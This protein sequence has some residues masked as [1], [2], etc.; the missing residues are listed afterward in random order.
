M[1]CFVNDGESFPTIADASVDFVFSFDSLVHAEGDVMQR[2]ICELGRILTRDGV[3]FLH[4]SNLAAIGRAPFAAGK[5]PVIGRI[6]GETS[7]HW[8]ARSVDAARV[9][10]WID[11]ARLHCASQELVNW[12]TRRLIDCITVIARPGSHHAR[13]TQIAPNAGFMAEARSAR[14]VSELYPSGGK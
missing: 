13:A 1:Q 11:D 2:Y 9:R 3:A 8:R 14:I 7:N 6:V 12:G 4:H 10:G 5:L